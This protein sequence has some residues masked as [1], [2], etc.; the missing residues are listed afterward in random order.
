MAREPPSEESTM[1]IA[2]RR[3]IVSI[4]AAA[5]FFT[6][7]AQALETAVTDLDGDGRSDVLW[8]NTATGQLFRLGMN[9]LAP[10][11]GA[12]IY[13]ES[14]TRWKIVGDGDFNGDGRSD[15]AWRHDDDGRIYIMLM[16]AGG[17]PAGG[18]VIHAEANMRWSIVA[19]P[20]FDGD[21]RADLLWYN[22][23]SGQLYLM[24]MNGAAIAAQGTLFVEPN[25][26][27]RVAGAD[28]RVVVWR[29]RA[30]GEVYRQAYQGSPVAYTTS[31]AVIYVE[32]SSAWSI[33]GLADFNADG[34]ADLL[35][36]NS[37]TGQVFAHLLSATGATLGGGMLHTEGNLDWQVVA[38]GDY[39]GDGRSDLLWRNFATGQVY[40][41]RVVATTVASQAMVYTE[42]SQLWRIKGAHDYSQDDRIDGNYSLHMLSAANSLPGTYLVEASCGT[43]PRI[44][45]PSGVP[46]PTSATVTLQ[47]GTIASTP[48]Y[49]FSGQI[50]VVASG[51]RVDY[52]D[53]SFGNITCFASVNAAAGTGPW[54]LSG[55]FVF[56]STYAGGYPINRMASQVSAPNN[57]EDADIDLS[58]N[59]TCSAAASF[60]VSQVR[61]YLAEFVAES[62]SKVYCGAPGPQQFTTCPP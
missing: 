22:E 31:G 9:G 54:N 15:L 4:L 28:T 7:P 17:V 61:P 50:G 48:P 57:I 42:P 34:A 18:A 58:G 59:F 14:D 55:V 44:N 37:S 16:G 47:G 41:M 25:T 20:D 21:G 26:D 52:N 5:G 6:A 23:T 36:R 2:V 12:M 39:D 19:T 46:T 3:A 10:A 30:N 8:H 56:S 29:N 53:P 62:L 11:A 27:W 60:L 49:T 1:A 40:G 13:A 32:P 35:W 24:V 33:A 38:T 51:I 45:C 43:N